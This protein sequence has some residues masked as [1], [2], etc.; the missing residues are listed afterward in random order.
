MY[1]YK[2][3]TFLL[4]TPGHK[5]IVEHCSTSA[6]TTLP[7][8]T[9][10]DQVCSPWAMAWIAMLS[11]TSWMCTTLYNDKHGRDSRL[12]CTNAQ[13]CCWRA[14]RIRPRRTTF[15]GLATSSVHAIHITHQ[16]SNRRTLTQTLTHTHLTSGYCVCK[17]KRRARVRL[18]VSVS[19]AST[20]R[21][22][23]TRPRF[24][25]GKASWVTTP[26]ERE[27]EHNENRKP[28]LRWQKK[29][30]SQGEMACV[31]FCNRSDIRERPVL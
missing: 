1:M 22:L 6:C 15:Y 29:K 3:D 26:P 5:I 4:L 19:S 7:L 9:Q 10:V 20:E 13:C 25:L 11:Y 31:W 8:F 12:A 30:K 23:P 28:I 21:S 18:C 24:V 27:R 16:T 14:H 17:K 2:V